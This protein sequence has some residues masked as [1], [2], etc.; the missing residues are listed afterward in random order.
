MLPRNSEIEI[1]IR[2]WWCGQR[3]CV[4]SGALLDATDSDSTYTAFHY[5][6]EKHNNITSSAFKL[7]KYEKQLPDIGDNFQ[8]IR[9]GQF[10]SR[11]NETMTR[12]D[13]TVII[14]DFVILHSRSRRRQPTR[15]SKKVSH[16]QKSSLDRIKNRQC[17]YISHQFLV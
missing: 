15:W 13:E 1:L 17:G 12:R 2:R 16:Y 10:V 8:L 14:Y 4:H 9:A 3:S 11:S 7:D 5:Q 6:V